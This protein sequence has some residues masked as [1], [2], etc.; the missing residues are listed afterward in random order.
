MK[1]LF[2]ALAALCCVASL[3]AATLKLDGTLSWKISKPD[4]T[5]SLDGSLQ[6]LSPS[7][8]S[9]GTL[10]LV[11]WATPYAYPSQ[12]YRLATCSLGQLGGGYQFTSHKWTGV[13]EVPKITGEYYF[14]VSV[15]EYYGNTWMN[16]A[17]YTTG[18]KLLDN[19]EF[20]TGA[21]WTAPVKPI[22][23]P[24]SK[25]TVGDKIILK[26]RADED[27]DKITSGTRAKTQIVIRK[28]GKTVVTIGEDRST[29]TRDYSNGFAK[30]NKVRSPV[31][32]L[33]L[34]DTDSSD[35]STIT[36]FYQSPTSGIY[37][38]VGQDILGGGTIWGTFTHL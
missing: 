34:D 25:L 28:R 11:L 37:R 31:G 38:S 1:T 16:R 23:A 30:Y 12:G 33:V 35:T 2:R 3:Q 24:P 10:I 27:F 26:A 17:F 15:M 20:V 5:F 7:G 6:N 32:K 8:S 19:G 14:T 22:I 9:S 21:K 29:W 36:L 18:R 4:C 13:A